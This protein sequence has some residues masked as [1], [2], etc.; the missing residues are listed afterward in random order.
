MDRFV[1]GALLSMAMV[2]YYT[3]PY[4]LAS[5]LTILSIPIVNVLF[6][7]FASASSSDPSR[8]ARLFDWGVRVAAGVLYPFALVLAVFP[9]EVLTLWLGPEFAAH[10]AGVLSLLAAGVF[11]NG[12]AQVALA[13]VQASGRPDLGARLHLAELPFYAAMVWFLIRT[14]GIVGAAVA[15]LVRALVD[16]AVLFVLAG[17]MQGGGAAG[18]RTAAIA[19]AFGLLSL[20]LG[21][22]TPSLPMRVVIVAASLIVY[23]V[24]GWRTIVVPGQRAI[25]WVALS[26]GDSV[27][28]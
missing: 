23:A 3:T 11:V 24:W 27:T 5:R 18:A 20:T 19:A 25:G 4:D 13:R 26:R 2:A 9:R 8:A 10:S 28:S 21:A 7:A 17:R 12:M 22:L 1:I 14:Q 16:A 15:W 6:P